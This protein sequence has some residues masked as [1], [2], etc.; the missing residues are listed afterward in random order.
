MHLPLPPKPE[1]R[2]STWRKYGYIHTIMNPCYSVMLR[3]ASRKV[4]AIYDEAL[5]PLGI[6]IAQFSL[7]RRIERLQPVSMTDLARSAQLDRSTI[8]RNAKV[9][10]RRGLVGAGRGDLDQ[11]EATITLTE[12]GA[13]LLAEAG[14]VWSACQKA[15]EARLGPVKI[16][17][18][19]EILRSV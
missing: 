11:R 19:E 17:A 12:A 9:L 18:L 2:I 15:M 4:S 10:E 16:T 6:N 13:G 14:P 1:L 5:S 8:G 3:E 7:L